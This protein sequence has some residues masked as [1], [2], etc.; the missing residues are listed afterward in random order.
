[1]S[2]NRNVG[3][4]SQL[5]VTPINPATAQENAQIEDKNEQ[6]MPVK[7]MESPTE[8][9]EVIKSGRSVSKLWSSVQKTAKSVSNRLSSTFSAQEMS[10]SKQKP[11]IYE[12][13]VAKKFT[14]NWQRFTGKG[15]DGMTNDLTTSRHVEPDD[16]NKYRRGPLAVEDFSGS[17]LKHITHGTIDSDDEDERICRPSSK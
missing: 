2:I 5:P 11:Q 16:S 17:S 14:R 3:F 1:M 15:K 10:A 8:A 12:M 9:N 13:K 6:S 7:Q 4:D